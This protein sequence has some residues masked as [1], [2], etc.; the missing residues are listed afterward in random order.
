MAPPLIALSSYRE[1]ARWGVWDQ[2]AD[3]LP[4]NYSDMVVAAGGLPVL[5]PPVALCTSPPTDPYAA[6]ATAL[7]ARV[8]GLLITG[9]ADVDPAAYGRVPG[10]RTDRP[11]T[12]RD[13]WELALLDAAE[14]IALPTLGVCR[15]MQLMAVRAGGELAQHLPD[16]VGHEGHSPGR[17]VFGA[18][19]AVIDAG[20]RLR[21]ITG[22]DEVEVHCHHHQGVLD[23]PGFTATARSG[24]GVLEAMELPG[25]RFCLAVQWHPENAEDTGLFRALVTAAAAG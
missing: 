17:D 16:V 19:R 1:P 13:A 3:L 11:R 8:D 20:S 2:L 7:L 18:T 24:D 10:P 9:G 6:S 14:R 5:A 25:P 15:G 4:A 22:S 12:D 23:H 21:E